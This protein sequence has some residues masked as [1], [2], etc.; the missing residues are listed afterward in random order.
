VLNFGH[1]IGHA[2]E[3]WSLKNDKNPLKHGEAVAI[4]MLCEAFISNKLLGLSNK[5]LNQIV[6][7][8]SKNFSHYKGKWELNELISYMK[9]DKKNY[10]GNYNFSLLKK[11]GKAKI[12][13]DCST[14]LILESLTYYQ[15]LGQQFPSQL[16]A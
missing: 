16:S 11:V 5:E 7:F 6:Q 12:D 14:D 13:V 15:G 1:T 4:G 2:I 8:I 3:T 9:N 10:K